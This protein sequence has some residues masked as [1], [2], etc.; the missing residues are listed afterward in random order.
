[1]LTEPAFAK[2]RTGTALRIGTV[3]LTNHHKIMIMIRIIESVKFC[4]H[5]WQIDCFCLAAGR[6]APPLKCCIFANPADLFRRYKAEL[7]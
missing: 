4:A 5:N 7:E 3:P 1:M 2:K 6:N